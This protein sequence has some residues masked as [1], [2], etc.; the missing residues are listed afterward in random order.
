MTSASTK[1][2]LNADMRM[3]VRSLYL[4][5]A[6]R[7]RVSSSETEVFEDA[8]SVD[9]LLGAHTR[10][11][12]HGQTSVLELLRL[13]VGK[14]LSVLG[15][16]GRSKSNVTGVVVFPKREQGSESGLHPAGGGAEGL[17]DV[18][19]EEEGEEDSS[20]NLRDLVVGDCER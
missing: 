19:R 11:R 12:K 4:H 6:H 10:G 3:K 13:H 20:R 15:L 1:S 16:N 8:L 18:D 5:R 17:G 2:Y 14:V 7:P 9:Q